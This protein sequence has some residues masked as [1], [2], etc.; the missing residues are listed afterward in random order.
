MYFG[1]EDFVGVVNYRWNGVVGEESGIH[2]C[3]GCISI[4]EELKEGVG[5]SCSMDRR[6]GRAMDPHKISRHAIGSE[7]ERER[8]HGN[9]FNVKLCTMY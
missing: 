8:K 4:G 6:R 1:L 7:G 9:P 2:R 5:N 3:D